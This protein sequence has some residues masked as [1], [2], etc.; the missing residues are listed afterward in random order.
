[1]SFVPV[2]DVLLLRVPPPP[3]VRRS[4]FDVFVVPYFYIDATIYSKLVVSIRERCET[5][6]RTFLAIAALYASSIA[7]PLVTSL[8]FFHL[9]WNAYTFMYSKICSSGFHLQ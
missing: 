3:H 2:L 9:P 5:H 8:N 6:D 7:S 1:M 4:S